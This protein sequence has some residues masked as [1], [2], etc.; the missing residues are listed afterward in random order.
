MNFLLHAFLC[1]L[2]W[3]H[4]IKKFS[5]PPNFHGKMR[6]F[7]FL[8]LLSWFLEGILQYL[9]F[10][11]I[12]DCRPKLETYKFQSKMWIYFFSQSYFSQVMIPNSVFICSLIEGMFGNDRVFLWRSIHY[13]LYGQ[14]WISIFDIIGVGHSLKQ[15]L[16]PC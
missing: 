3:K 5:F 13:S 14:A 6:N 8:N 1:I 16:M 10:P 11:I 15:G 7:P 2:A 12:D 4:V 9:V